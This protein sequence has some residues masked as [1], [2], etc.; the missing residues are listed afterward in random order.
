MPVTA[1]YRMEW[2]ASYYATTSYSLIQ[3][4]IIIII[5]PIPIIIIIIIIIKDS[6][7]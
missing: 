1:M 4:T 5:I 7:N 3:K 2:C 6:L